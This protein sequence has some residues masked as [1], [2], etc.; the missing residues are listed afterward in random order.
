MDNTNISMYDLREYM[1]VMKVGSSKILQDAQYKLS[2]PDKAGSM[3]YASPH[4]SKWKLLQVKSLNTKD[5]RCHLD[6][7]KISG[8]L[9]KI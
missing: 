7:F 4:N 6:N 1:H 3:N 8:D 9:F 5:L 2:N